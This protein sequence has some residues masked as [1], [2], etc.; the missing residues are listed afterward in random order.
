M[1]DPQFNI[2]FVP[3][4]LLLFLFILFKTLAEECM[5]YRLIIDSLMPLIKININ[6]NDEQISNYEKLSKF[7][8]YLLIQ[9]VLSSSWKC[10]PYYFRKFMKGFFFIYL[11]NFKLFWFFFFVDN[12]DL[13]SIRWI[14]NDVSLTNF[15]LVR[16]FIDFFDKIKNEKKL[17]EISFQANSIYKCIKE[18]FERE[19]VLMRTW[20]V[21]NI[22][23]TSSYSS[24]FIINLIHDINTMLDIQQTNY[25]LFSQ[26][27]IR[28]PFFYPMLLYY[29]FF[30][31][32]PSH[33]SNSFLSNSLINVIDTTLFR[34]FICDFFCGISIIHNHGKKLSKNSISVFFPSSL[35]YI[36]ISRFI[37]IASGGIRKI[38]RNF[39]PYTISYMLSYLHSIFFIYKKKIDVESKEFEINKLDNV[40]V[41][42]KLITDS[43]FLIDIPRQILNFKSLVDNTN[44]GN[45][46]FLNFESFLFEN[47]KLNNLTSSNTQI[48]EVLNSCN[49]LNANKST[50]CFNSSFNLIEPL[51]K[52]VIKNKEISI[53]EK[54]LN[55]NNNGNNFNIIDDLSLYL[56]S[57]INLKFNNLGESIKDSIKGLSQNIFN[58]SNWIDVGFNLLRMS[59]LCFTVEYIPIIANN[60]FNGEK[61]LLNLVRIPPIS[62]LS[63]S[64]I[65]SFLVSNELSV[66][67]LLH[68][69]IISL[70]VPLLF[71]TVLFEKHSSFSFASLVLVSVHKYSVYS[72]LSPFLK[73]YPHHNNN[74]WETVSVSDPSILLSKSSEM[75][76]PSS[77]FNLLNFF[78][79]RPSVWLPHLFF[80]LTQLP[81]SGHNNYA[82]FIC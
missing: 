15:R 32:L 45:Y 40:D 14:I 34:C 26:K 82:G 56:Y 25:S 80:L 69:V 29:S 10:G 22:S 52:R 70:I 51:L 46:S 73:I 41:P 36:I 74:L 39:D 68:C 53:Q 35:S 47:R 55:E 44:F 6:N 4:H 8:S 57:T 75:A 54:N 16:S 78:Q 24:D 50:F 42:E 18:D 19:L 62:L 13:F 27:L 79:Q 43:L 81:F 30:Y 28:V 61:S 7:A 67:E 38:L 58:I 33:P 63:G 76:N 37:S 31:R 3:S 23:N 64:S 20:I 11:S 2:F 66:I 71:S 48:G 65:K 17:D 5:E 1:I 59:D 60:L 49:N 21:V 72:D 12:N 77:V 9:T